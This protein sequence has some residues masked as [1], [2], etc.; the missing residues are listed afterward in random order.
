MSTTATTIATIH[1]AT[2]HP[3]SSVPSV[4]QA[5]LAQP[6]FARAIAVARVSVKGVSMYGRRLVCG[7][8]I[9]IGVGLIVSHLSHFLPLEFVTLRERHRE[10][11]KTSRTKFRTNTTSPARRLPKVHL[12]AYGSGPR[13]AKRIV[14]F[15]AEALATGS[16]M[17]FTRLRS[18]RTA[19]HQMSV[20]NYISKR[21]VVQ[22]IGFGSQP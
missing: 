6:S 5:T 11:H 18:F 8:A 20:G 16:S 19:S 9:L 21:R 14:N 1:A 3:N 15:R 17:K 13:Y 4:A 2:N 22:A 12:L 10:P 7:Y